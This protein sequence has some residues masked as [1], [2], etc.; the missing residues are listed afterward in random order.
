MRIIGAVVLTVALTAMGTCRAIEYRKRINVMQELVLMLELM[1]SELGT[2]SASM[3]RI[4]KRIQKCCSGDIKKFADALL[5]SMDRLGE[6]EF[7]VLWQEAEKETLSVLNPD[8][9][10]E[11]SSLGESLGKYN[12][13]MQIDAI[14]RCR[15]A[16]VGSINEIKPQS[17]KIQ[18]MY[19]G[20]Y[21]GAGLI[22]S[23]M[24]I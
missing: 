1:K 18:K 12:A 23:V 15:R 16:V 2:S 7:S 22:V 4:I 13:D 14:E 5:R 8:C 3:N 11:I 17:G 21:G 24:L 19:I 6:T 9:F 20:L 10:S